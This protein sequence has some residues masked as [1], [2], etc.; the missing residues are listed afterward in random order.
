MAGRK[1]SNQSPKRTLFGGGKT[2][3]G[4]F[5]LGESDA[6]VEEAN[7]RRKEAND[8]AEFKRRMKA[9]PNDASIH[10]LSKGLFK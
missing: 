9:A 2:H 1:Y 4:L 6:D 10:S 7:R 8:Q 3:K 5:G